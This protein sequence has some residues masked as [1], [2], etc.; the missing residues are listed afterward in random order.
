MVDLPWLDPQSLQREGEVLR[1]VTRP[2]MSSFAET[3]SVSVTDFG[4]HEVSISVISAPRS[5]GTIVDYGKGIENVEELKRAIES[6][7]R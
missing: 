4:P 5:I 7:L 2:S 1:A 3:L 6:W